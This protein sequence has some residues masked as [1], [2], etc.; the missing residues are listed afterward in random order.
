VPRA[1]LSADAV[2]DAAIR[3]ADTSGLDALTLAA[4]AA[5]V[6]VQTPSLYKHVAGLPALR[7]EIGLRAKHDLARALSRAA[8]GKSRRDALVALATT[9]RSWAGDNPASAAALQRAPLPGDDQDLEASA[10]VTQVVFAVLEGYGLSEDEV[11]DATRTLRA[12]LVGWTSLEANDG[13]GMARPVA[14]SFGWWV[15]G[16][17]RALSAR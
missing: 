7:R 17:D 2:I 8:A 11:I 10:E 14:D 1:G 5:D 9:Y 13:F 12:M 16:F 4:V 6:G 15:D 3:L